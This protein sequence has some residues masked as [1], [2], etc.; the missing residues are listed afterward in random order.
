MKKK[1]KV[2]SKAETSH[3]KFLLGTNF[4][5]KVIKP[6]KRGVS[7]GNAD[8]ALLSRWQEG[9]AV[10]MPVCTLLTLSLQKRSWLAQLR[11]LYTADKCMPIHTF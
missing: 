2:H 4:Y 9:G 10:V 5:G 7:N 3:A 1:E 11:A 6:L 8:T